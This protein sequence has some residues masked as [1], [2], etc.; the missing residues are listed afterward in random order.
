MFGLSMFFTVVF[1]SV[2]VLNICATFSGLGF[3]VATTIPCTLLTRY[4]Q[5]PDL[6]FQRYQT[7]WSLYR[8]WR[9]YG[10]FR[11]HLLLVTDN[12]VSIYGKTSG[13]HWVASFLHCYIVTLW[14]S[15]SYHGYQS[16]FYPL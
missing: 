13:S 12:F 5:Q 11:L 9:R 3:A 6:F 7:Y 15:F 10:C 2:V 1:P 8:N 16:G 4:H 14:V